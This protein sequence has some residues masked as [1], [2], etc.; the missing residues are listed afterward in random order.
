MK[1]LAIATRDVGIWSPN[2]KGPI[3]AVFLQG[4][5]TRQFFSLWLKIS[6]LK[7]PALQLQ[8]LDAGQNEQYLWAEIEI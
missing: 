7:T 2:Y 4:S 6:M 5:F 3:A 8:R 1:I